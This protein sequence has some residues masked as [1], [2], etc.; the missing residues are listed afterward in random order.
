M[1]ERYLKISAVKI[2]GGFPFSPFGVYLNFLS[3]LVSINYMYDFK[4]KL[5]NMK[6]L[7]SLS[8]LS[9]RLS[10][11]QHHKRRKS[12][13]IQNMADPWRHYVKRKKLLTERWTS[14]DTTCTRHIK[15]SN[16]QKQKVGWW[17]SGAGEE[18]G[19]GGNGELVFGY[20]RW[21]SSRICCT[22]LCL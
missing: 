21:L 9:K 16:I 2:M 6:M 5:L 7:I 1:F 10:I 11:I 19:T 4:S 12:C 14:C 3:F 20:T 8:S 18:G 13:H 15:Q 22:T 17:L